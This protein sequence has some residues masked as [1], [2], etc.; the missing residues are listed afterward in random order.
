MYSW[1]T[2]ALVRAAV[3]EPPPAT[4]P[5]AQGIEY[6]QKLQAVRGFLHWVYFELRTL[7]IT[8]E[9]RALNFAGTNA[10]Q[11]QSIFES[12]IQD[13]MELDSIDIERSQICRPDSDCWDVKVSFFYP[14]REVQ[15]VRKAYRFTVD[16]SDVVPVMVGPVRSWFTR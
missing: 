15:S 11:I 5:V 2:D 6:T 16:V 8:A 7:G 13:A 3:G 1:T 9:E 14:K 10:F 4:A 12:A